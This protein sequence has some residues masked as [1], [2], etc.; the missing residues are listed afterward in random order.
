MPKTIHIFALISLAAMTALPLSATPKTIVLGGENGWSNLSVSEG[1]TTGKGRFGY[2]CLQLV[3]DTPALTA[4]TDLLLSFDDASFSDATGNY[5]VEENAL[6]ATTASVR[7]NGAA[8]SRGDTTGITLRGGDSSLFG[9]SGL[10]GSFTIEFWLNPSIA[11]NGEKVFSWRSSRNV[12]DYSA[13]QMITALFF[14][15]HLEWNFSG[16]FE[17]YRENEVSLI[18]YSTVIPDTWTRHTLSFDEE[19]GLLEYC[20]DGKT[21]A[22][23]Y[24][25]S[26][27]HQ[28]GT[29]CQ[30]VLGVRSSIEI[31]P[32]YTGR[33]DNFRIE[34][35]PY[36]KNADN[37]YASGNET[38]RI[39][40]GR[41]MTQPILASQAA[42]LDRIHAIMTVPEQ[43]EVLLYVRSGENCFGWT[44]SWPEWKRI[45]SDRDI[46]GVTGLYFQIAAEL[47]PDGGGTKTP[48]LT[49]L[50][51]QYTEQPLPLAPFTVR[52][53]P[54]NGS[55][56]LTWSYSVDDNAGGYY[57]YY[58]NKSGE[59]LGRVALEGP[60]PIK[61]GNTT[62]LTLTGLK[63]GTIYYFAISAYSRIDDRISGLL[64]KEVYARPSAYK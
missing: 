5:T 31:C 64:S 49:E 60:S 21:E 34:R 36:N 33:L 38:Y 25:T 20:V 57:V 16:I 35:R 48:T 63:N 51:V 43:T 3:T 28:G 29:V 22:V 18:G 56:T 53:E 9:R 37:L 24:I 8:L 15:N 62:S 52:A 32:G 42:T 1:I 7:G 10:T 47:L 19:S 2:D 17:G 58:G 13:Y 23:R 6:V 11:E 39:E 61:V 26:T 41:F 54:G 27:A 14:N 55:V 50:D 4:E 59:Y 40:G 12:N 46:T 45:S 30:P 44:E